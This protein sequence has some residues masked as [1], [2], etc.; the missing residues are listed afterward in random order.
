MMA[1]IHPLA[2]AAGLSALA[3]SVYWAAVATESPTLDRVAEVTVSLAEEDTVGGFDTGGTITRTEELVFA[4]GETEKVIG[5][6]TVAAGTLHQY[7]FKAPPGQQLTVEL[8]VE[9]NNAAFQVQDLIKIDARTRWTNT[10]SEYPAIAARR[11]SG[12]LPKSENRQFRILVGPTDNRDASYL[13]RVVLND[14]NISSETTKNRDK[15]IGP[16]SIP[17][18]NEQWKKETGLRYGEV[19]RRLIARGWI[20]HT[21]E[22]TGPARHSDPLGLVKTMY[23][24][25][26]EEVVDCAGTGLAPCRFE[27]V[28]RDRALDNGPVLAVIATV[29]SGPNPD[30]YFAGMNPNA[31]G[32]NTEYEERPFNAALFAEI[33]NDE[34]F[35]GAIGT[36][37]V[38]SPYVL[39]NS[40]SQYA[41]ADVAILARAYPEGGNRLVV[42][43]RKPV[44]RAQAL[45]Y[46]EILDRDQTIDLSD[47]NRQRY[48]GDRRIESYAAPGE[49][50]RNLMQLVLTLNGQVSEIKFTK[51]GNLL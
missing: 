26:Y 31:Y 7:R 43:P 45:R 11:W 36:C 51:P 24:L 14:R 13:M 32:I 50:P 15:E 44:S 29:A 47:R 22:T 40:Q 27:F 46:A 33:Q 16:S 10:L 19:R 28:Y 30:P 3:G 2:I 9:N 18:L 48:D 34:N 8:Q 12:M 38:S 25:G 20:P 1:R 4:P 37:P 21:I 49:G 17:S 35:C 41:F 6:G 39:H 5:G 23:G 42:F